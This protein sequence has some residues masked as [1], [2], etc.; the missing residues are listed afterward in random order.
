MEETFSLMSILDDLVFELLSLLWHYF[1]DWFLRFEGRAPPE[2]L[3]CVAGRDFGLR[4]PTEDGD[5]KKS[6]I[7]RDGSFIASVIWPELC[8]QFRHGFLHGGAMVFDC[9]SFLKVS[10]SVIT[11]AYEKEREFASLVCAYLLKPGSEISVHFD[12]SSF[13]MQFAVSCH[14]VM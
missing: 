9:N 11:A 13:A 6:E 2:G 8:R 12:F 14:I 5:W 10:R 1:M 3:Y 7:A 4:L